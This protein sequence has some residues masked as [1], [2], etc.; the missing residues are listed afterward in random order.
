[1]N[2]LRLSIFLP[3][4]P[5]P[6]WVVRLLDVCGA[7][8]GVILVG[9]LYDAQPMAAADWAEQVDRL[10][11]DRGASSLDP[12]SLELPGLLPVL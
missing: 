9:V 2:V 6:G 1:M 5:V 7:E 10:L 11:F 4:G 8:P 3:D 12:V